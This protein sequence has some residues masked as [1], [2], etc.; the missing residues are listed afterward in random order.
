[1]HGLCMATAAKAKPN[2]RRL[3]LRFGPPADDLGPKEDKGNNTKKKKNN[4][5]KRQLGKVKE[6]VVK[7]QRA[8]ATSIASLPTLGMRCGPCV[9]SPETDIHENQED[10]SRLNMPMCE[11]VYRRMLHTSKYKL[12][13]DVHI[14]TRLDV[15]GHPA[16]ARPL[17]SATIAA[18]HRLSK[19]VIEAAAHDKG[20]DDCVTRQ[21][22][23]C[24]RVCKPVPKPCAGTPRLDA[25]SQSRM[26]GMA[27]IAWDRCASA[28]AEI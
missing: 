4:K 10:D 16:R 28:S 3:G 5:K 12:S 13:Q 11:H 2:L 21:K 1:M 20:I 25:R 18:R 24:T 22:P 15:V 14:V 19:G 27:H 23:T 8:S 7:G 17:Y 6:K 9:T 26:V